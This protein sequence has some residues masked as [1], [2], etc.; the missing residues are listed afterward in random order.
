MLH[1]FKFQNHI[2]THRAAND[3]AIGRFQKFKT[4]STKAEQK[5]FH[6]ISDMNTLVFHLTLKHFSSTEAH[7]MV[8]YQRFLSLS[9]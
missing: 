9:K 4:L 2:E 1:L 8:Y 3:N 6:F 5:R 7:N